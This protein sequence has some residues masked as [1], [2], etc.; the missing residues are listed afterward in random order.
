MKKKLLIVL[1]LLIGTF[2]PAQTVFVA[3]NNKSANN[4]RTQMSKD[5]AKGRSC[6]VP[7]DDPSK[8]DLRMEVNEGIPGSGTFAGLP[9][10]SVNVAD[11][12]G[13]VVFR[14]DSQLAWSAVYRRLQKQLC[15]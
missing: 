5:S 7:E 14:G 15:K 1:A 10:V 9:S 4:I 13:K 11:R 6:L 8:A 3:S 2:A 12:S